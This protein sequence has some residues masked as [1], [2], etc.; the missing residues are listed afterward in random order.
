MNLKIDELKNKNNQTHSHKYSNSRNKHVEI[1]LFNGIIVKKEMLNV[2]N[3]LP[4]F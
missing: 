3:F 2:S 4:N 1:P